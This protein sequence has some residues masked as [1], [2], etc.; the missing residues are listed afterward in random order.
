MQNRSIFFNSPVNKA[1]CPMCQGSVSRVRRNFLDRLL[2]PLRGLF[3][4]RRHALYRYH[5]CASA[6]A[7]TG[8]LV[9]RVGRR[10]LYGA[11]GSRRHVL[12]AARMSG[13]KT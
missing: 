12:D 11:S 4:S 5:C 13:L 2:D 7:W 1:A 9:R 8:T 3:V 10:D 6:C